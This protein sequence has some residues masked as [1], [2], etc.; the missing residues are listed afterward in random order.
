MFRCETS[1]PVS[2]GCEGT[3]A[4]A[5]GSAVLSHWKRNETALGALAFSSQ[6]KAMTLAYLYKPRILHARGEQVSLLTRA[7][8]D[9]AFTSSCKMM[10]K[11]MLPPIWET[12]FILNR[13]F[14]IKKKKTL[15]FSTATF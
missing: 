10:G 2:Q 13:Y 1:N 3:Q 7:P 5:P 8:R 4:H 15:F 12:S 9:A 6:Y 11:G 14:R